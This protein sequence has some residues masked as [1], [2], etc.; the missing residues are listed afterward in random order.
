MQQATT[1]PS[2]VITS[3]RV[4]GT[5]VFNPAGDSLGSI[6]HLVIDK[7]SGAVRY[8]VLEFGGI[9]GMGA[10]RYPLPWSMLKYDA[11]KEGYVVPLEK[12][13]LSEAP[14]YSSDARPAY[15]DQYTRGIREY[16]GDDL[17]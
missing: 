7:R 13:Q 4:A 17:I 8:A 10:D 15:D 3:D 6:D 2:A 9:L 11:D 14:R 16:Y 1:L 12:E 5:D